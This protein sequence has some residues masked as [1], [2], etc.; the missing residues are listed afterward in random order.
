MSRHNMIDGQHIILS[1]GYERCGHLL[2]VFGKEGDRIASLPLS[3]EEGAFLAESLDT[4]RVARP[5][6]TLEKH[7]K[8]RK[9]LDEL[10]PPP[11]AE[12][13]S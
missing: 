5:E 6:E 9:E 1:S 3:R 2:E 7:E 10:A 11:Q 4:V 12:A 8:R 13:P